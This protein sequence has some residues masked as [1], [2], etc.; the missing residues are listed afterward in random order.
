MSLTAA[1]R[2]RVFGE[3]DGLSTLALLPPRT[4]EGVVGRYDG[5][6]DGLLRKLKVSRA[7]V[8]EEWSKQRRK[9]VVW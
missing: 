6:I 5:R 3:S 4:G 7:S 9:R 2:G 1:E 8:I